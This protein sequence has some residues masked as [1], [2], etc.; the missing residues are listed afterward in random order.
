MLVDFTHAEAC[1]AERRAPGLGRRA[2]AAS[3]GAFAPPPKAR[4][5]VV[6]AAGGVV[7]SASIVTEWSNFRGGDYWWIQSLYIRPSIAARAWSTPCWPTSPTRPGRRGARSAALRLQHQRA[8]AARL[9]A[10]RLHRRP[11][12]RDDTAPRQALTTGGAAGYD[13]SAGVNALS[14]SASDGGWRTLPAANS[15]ACG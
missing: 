14:M 10:L 9:P 13:D 4:Y 15:S 7:A 3:R 11:V 1:D 12:H 2:G 5:W 6:E 8:R